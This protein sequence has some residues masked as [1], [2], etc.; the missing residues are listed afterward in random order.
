VGIYTKLR[1]FLAL[2]LLPPPP[3]TPE[4]ME[5][6]KQIFF[7]RCAG[8]HGALRKGATGPSL[9]PENRTR[10]LG[11]EGI[12]VFITY[13]TRRG[14]HDWVRQGILSEKEIDILA[15]FS[16]HDPPPPTELPMKQMKKSWK[17][18]VETEKRPKS[19]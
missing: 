7:N 12:K 6:A 4:E 11:T 2:K 19:P 16:Q 10:L 15:R 14:M 5:I 1:R 18:Y 13:G 8:C 17:V 9:L 3:I